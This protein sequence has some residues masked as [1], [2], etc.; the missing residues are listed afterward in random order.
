MIISPDLA[1]AEQ[2]KIL[3]GITALVKEEK[4]KIEPSFLGKKPLAYPIGKSSEGNYWL[5]TFQSAG[6]E[7]V[8]MKDTMKTDGRIL[9][10]LLLRKQ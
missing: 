5:L 3:A 4:K 1:E 9:R 2:K 8:S 7:A 6:K 10:Y